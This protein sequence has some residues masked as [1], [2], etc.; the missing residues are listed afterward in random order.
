MDVLH[1]DGF[2]DVDGDGRCSTCGNYTG[3]QGIDFGLAYK[4]ILAAAAEQLRAR[5]A[6]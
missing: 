3:H 6:G 5:H 2:H 4:P 1:N